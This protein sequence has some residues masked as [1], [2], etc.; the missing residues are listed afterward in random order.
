M[1]EWIPWFLPEVGDA[2]AEAAT[3]VIGENFINDGPTTRKFEQ[4]TAEYLGVRHCVGVTSGTAA[5]TLALLAVGVKPGD[6][7]IVPD[8]TFIATANAARMIGAN[9]VLV[10]V[11]PERFTIDCD[12]VEAAITP[13]TRAIVPVDV[14]GRA[15]DY[16]RLQDICDRHGLALISDTAE[17]FGSRHRNR[18]LGTIAS[19]GCFS[20][21]SA[22]T[23]TMGQGGL[24]AT[25]DDILHDRLRELK[26]QGRRHGG[27]GGDDLHPVFGYNFKLTS[28]QA[29]VGLAQFQ[30]LETRLAG[31][32]A[33]D[34]WYR[35]RL[36]DLPGVTL[37]PMA[38]GEEVRQWSDILLD[39]RDRIIA[40]L[41]ADKIDCRPFWLPLHRQAPYLQSDARFPVSCDISRRGSWLPSSFSLTEAQAEWIA[42]RI[43]QL[44]LTA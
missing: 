3:K 20:F 6:E 4:V 43:R 31:F 42:T 39:D 16:D 36:S 17:G 38:D 29:A 8:M 41:R 7:V 10:D 14:N 25:D 24:C 28:L 23:I 26:D 44:T 15:A 22:K 13:R 30:R 35:S 34:S 19:I 11:E 32:Q 21:S 12:A 37:P 9:V 27:T 1:S 18:A 33:R 2:E 40:A 5:I